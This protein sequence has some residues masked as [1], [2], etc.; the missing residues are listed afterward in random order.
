VKVAAYQAPLS[1][2]ESVSGAVSLIRRQIDR[3][4]SSGV[5][6]LCCPEAILGGLADYSPRSASLAIGVGNGRLQQ[7]LELLASNTVTTILGFT[8][9]DDAGRLYN[10]AAV[11]HRGSVV[12]L[13]RK[14]HPAINRSVYQPGMSMPVFTAGDLTFGIIICRD[15]T[16]NEPASI[17]AA[18]GATVLFV[19]TNNGLPPGKTGPDIIA[20]ARKDD[21][22]RAR[23][24][25]VSIVRADVAGRTAGLV[26]YGCS[27]IVDRSGTVLAAA[28]PLEPGLVVADVDA[29]P[30]EVP[31]SRP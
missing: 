20:A 7:I 25:H 19:P 23:E 29:T 16:F 15:S 5:K 24:S 17:M 9:A 12:G 14:H 18:Q 13:Y 31:G 30:R 28:H 8:E 26:A 3:C 10:S 4:E 2:C 1:A 21:T 22:A 6:F 11:L 27:E